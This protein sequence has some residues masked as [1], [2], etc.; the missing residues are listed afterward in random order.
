MYFNI[1]NKLADNQRFAPNVSGI[2]DSER[3]KRGDIRKLNITARVQYSTQDSETI[4]GIETRLYIM[5]GTRELDVLPWESVNKTFLE[6][7]TVIDTNILVPQ[8]Y[9]LDIKIKYGMEEIIHHD[10]LHFDI[11]DDINNRYA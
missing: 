10:V 8:R 5:D 2:N 3:I 4:N 9:Y 11:V 1:G 7:Y 6:N